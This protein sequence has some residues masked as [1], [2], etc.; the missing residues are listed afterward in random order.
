MMSMCDFPLKFLLVTPQF[1]YDEQGSP[2]PGGLLQFNRCLARALASSPGLSSLDVWCQVDSPRRE[3]QMQ[4]LVQTY[5]HPSL[6]LRV[7]GFGASRLALLGAMAASCRQGRFDRV[8]YTLLNQ[9]LLSELPCHPP[10][11]IWQIGAEFFQRLGYAKRRAMRRASRVFSISAHTTQLAAR[12]TPG[13]REGTVIPLCSEPPDRDPVIGSREA[14][15]LIVGNMHESML[16]KGHQQ[17]IAAWPQVVSICPHAKLW[18]VG[19]GDGA[20]LL[21]DQVN[22]LS[23][24]VRHAIHFFGSV[25]EPVLDR[26]Y[27]A[28]R[29]F[30]MPSTGEGFG[31][32]FVEAARYGLPCIGGKYDA[33]KEIIL[34]DQTGLLTEQNP[35]DIA[36]ACIRLLTNEAE[37]HRLGEAAR[38]RYS[39]YFR[40]THFRERLLSNMELAY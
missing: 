13:L 31:L 6:G 33:A 19:R 20:P 1:A 32:V 21:R 26:L 30:A 25:S 28:A 15:V 12:Y 7:R 11:D 27:G 40:F 2:T 29:I 37:A 9:A 22:L 4:E 39:N 3:P 17:L 16:Y 5:A 10:F 36:L 18:I 14:A 24:E 8:T 35:H 34:H 38:L 23:A